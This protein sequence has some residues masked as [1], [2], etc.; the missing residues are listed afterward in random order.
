MGAANALRASNNYL[1]QFISSGSQRPQDDLS[2]KE[3]VAVVAEIRVDPPAEEVRP[4]SPDVVKDEPLTAAST[5][6][7]ADHSSMAPSITVSQPEERQPRL[8]QLSFIDSQGVKQNS[9]ESQ[10]PSPESTSANHAPHHPDAPSTEFNQQQEAIHAQPASP[11]PQDDYYDDYYEEHDDHESQYPQEYEDYQEYQEYQEYLGYDPRR[12]TM[13]MRPLPPD[14]PSDNPEQ[15]ANRIR[16]FYKEYF[17]D[18]KQPNVPP[19]GQYYDGSE[20]YYDNHAPNAYHQGGYYQPPA[21]PFHGPSGRHRSTGSNGSYMS[22]PRAYSSAS[23][24]YGQP[25]AHMRM[26]KK[27][28]PPMPLNILPTPHLLKDDLFLPTDFAPPKK[29]QNQRAGT[30]DS[31]RGGIRPYTPTRAAATPLASSFDDLAVIPS[32]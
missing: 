31:L 11:N 7:V 14:D 18:S 28:P 13:G 29:F 15:R 5:A 22:R 21:A 19:N 12:L 1:A 2:K 8:P 10:S 23:G 25:G 30:P 32:P 9:L 4:P 26:K 27:L 24:R 17:D 20:G 3:P 16:S 6:H